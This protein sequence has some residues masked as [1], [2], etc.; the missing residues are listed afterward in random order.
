MHMKL[1]DLLTAKTPRQRPRRHRP[2]L[3][4]LLLATVLVLPSAPTQALFL[5]KSPAGFNKCNSWVEVKLA[6]HALYQLGLRPTS[7]VISSDE[8]VREFRD[9][10]LELVYWLGLD[11]AEIAGG[12]PLMKKLRGALFRWYA[13][14]LARQNNS[15]VEYLLGI[16][17]EA[18]MPVSTLLEW[19]EIQAP[20]RAPFVAAAAAAAAAAAGAADGAAAGG[21]AAAVAEAATAS[22]G[23]STSA[24]VSVG[25]VATL[26]T[27]AAVSGGSALPLPPPPPS[28]SAIAAARLAGCM[29]GKEERDGKDGPSR[30]AS[31]RPPRLVSPGAMADQKSMLRLEV[32]R[33]RPVWNVRVR[34]LV[35]E[36]QD[37]GWEFERAGRGSHNIYRNLAHPEWGSVTVPGRSAE[38][39]DVGTV[40]AIMKQA[41]LMD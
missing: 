20:P 11:K 23:S 26:P 15:T 16:L 22:P 28:L 38:V 9:E 19:A 36:M 10:E 18:E 1:R 35:E 27:M 7:L 21:A 2:T 31:D 4:A 30:A 25:A 13:N 34:E 32:R 17:S 3:R 14:E 12:G 5:V 40:R 33:R 29:D 24:S 6:L 37:V 39:L 8:R 41:H